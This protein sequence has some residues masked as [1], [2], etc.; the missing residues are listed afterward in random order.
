MICRDIEPQHDDFFKT[1]YFAC[2]FN[3]LQVQECIL[4]TKWYESCEFCGLVRSFLKGFWIAI[5][6][7]GDIVIKLLDMTWCWEIGGSVLANDVLQLGRSRNTNSDSRKWFYRDRETRLSYLLGKIDVTL[8]DMSG[9]K[10]TLEG[11]YSQLTCQ[12][13]LLFFLEFATKSVAG[14]NR[15]CYD[16]TYPWKTGLV[17]PIC[18]VYW[19]YEVVRR[20]YGVQ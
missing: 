12:L 2:P 18:A 3:L 11:D 9:S 17:L 19:Y 8:N 15:A 20:S 5:I 7:A 1:I 14:R 6:F 10:G 13:V 16:T 4:L